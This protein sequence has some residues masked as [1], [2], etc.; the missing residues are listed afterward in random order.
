[1]RETSRERRTDVDTRCIFMWR[2]CH[3]VYQPTTG[4]T[5]KGAARKLMTI[6]YCPRCQKRIGFMQNIG[7][8]VHSCDSGNATLDNEDVP[9]IGG[10]SD[11]TGDITI[12]T[13]K[14]MLQGAENKLGANRAA[15]QGGKTHS[16]T[17]RGK[18]T[19]THRTRQHLQY[20]ETNNYD[21]V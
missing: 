21:N 20:I 8:F 13:R 19:S 16:Y 3:E 10:G 12:R 15:T 6:A 2:L 5:K 7:D 11:Y 9:Y 14:M 4:E 1:M 17:A 18:R